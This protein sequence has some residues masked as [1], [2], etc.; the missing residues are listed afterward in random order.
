MYTL[1]EFPPVREP[2]NNGESRKPESAGRKPGSGKRPA[3]TSLSWIPFAAVLAIGLSAAAGGAYWWVERRIGHL[4]EELTAARTELATARSS[5]RLLWTTTTRLDEAQARRQAGLQDSIGSVQAF[6]DSEVNKLWEGAYLEHGRRLDN[7]TALIGAHDR[8]IRTILDQSDQT[9]AR[10]DALFR[11]NET[12]YAGIRDVG[13]R[14]DAIGQSL[15]AV[16]GQVTDMQSRLANAQVARGQ[17]ATRIS[18]VEV[19]M[20]GFTGAGLNGE[21]VDQRLAA[22]VADLR[23]MTARVDSLRVVTDSVRRSRALVGQDRQVP[24]QH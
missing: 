16:T 4:E 19:W 2:R 5:L 9:S 24:Q 10:I 17:L 11:E 21:A 12:Q 3:P 6:F 1:E 7:N 22:L 13:E 8:S 23:T 14:L 18:G 15:A 20:D